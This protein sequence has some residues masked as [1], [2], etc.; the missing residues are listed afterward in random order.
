MMLD[1]V[2]ISILDLATKVFP[3]QWKLTLTSNT[4]L[5]SS[6]FTSVWLDLIC[7][8]LTFSE[9][10]MKLGGSISH[11]HGIG[12]HRKDFLPKQIQP[13]GVNTLRGIKKVIDPKNIFANGNLF[14]Q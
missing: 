2:F 1:H 9:E 5:G 4:P 14:D 13:L 7:E 6:L 8:L 3:M 11:H 12:K 10:I